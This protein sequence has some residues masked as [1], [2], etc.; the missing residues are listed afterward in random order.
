MNRYTLVVFVPLTHSDVVRK[1]LGDAGAGRQGNY[2]NC[3]FSSIGCGR[4][5]GNADSHP[6]IGSPLIDQIVEEERIEVLVLEK[7]I[8]NVLKAMRVSH[9]YEEIA[10]GVY[11][12]EDFEI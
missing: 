5:R 1:A 4:Y 3:S 6:A 10:Y 8:K 9:P 12:L 7:D 2:D 11:K